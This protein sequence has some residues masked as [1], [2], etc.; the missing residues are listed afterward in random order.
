MI[1]KG[2][3]LD[4]ELQAVVSHLMWVLGPVF[5]SSSSG[6]ANALD[7]WATCPAPFLCFQSPGKKEVQSCWDLNAAAVF[8]P[9]LFAA[10]SRI[11]QK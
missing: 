11:N 9:Q 5:R 4:L 6:A 3:S 2:I 10:L 7:S 1:R 8:E